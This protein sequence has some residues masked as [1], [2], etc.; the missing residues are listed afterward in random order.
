MNFAIYSRKSKYTSSG[1]S[2]ENQIN[3]CYE[4]I[5][6]N[7]AI[8]ENSIFIYKDEGFSGKNTNRP[9]FLQMMRELKT[10]NINCIVCYRLDRISRNVNDFS[11]LIEML[12]KNSISFISIRERF[13]TTTPMGKAMMYISSVFAQMER[14]TIAERI[15]DN[16]YKLAQ[17]GR[18]LGG[19]TPIGYK[20]EKISITSNDKTRHEF[21]L[22]LVEEE[23]VIVRKIYSIFLE[24]KRLSAVENYLYLNKIKTRSNKNYTS[25][26]IKDI[27]TNPVYCQ[28]DIKSLKYF[29]S[30]GCNIYTNE[31][32]IN[33]NVGY[34][35]YCKTKNISPSSS[36]RINT[37]YKEWI[38]S[39]GKHP[40]IIS[41]EN[42]IKTQNILKSIKIKHTKK[43]LNNYALL[44]GILFCK[45]TSPMRAK[46]YGDNK[47]IYMCENKEKSKNNNCNIKGIKG[48]TLDSLILEFII[49]NQQYSKKIYNKIKKEKN[50]TPEELFENLFINADINKKRKIIKTLI[51]FIIYDGKSVKIQY[52]NPESLN[53]S[54]HTQPLHA[55]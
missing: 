49:N 20:A 40:Y 23:S 55:R 17:T 34:M 6:Q 15:K 25:D 32:D 21:K 29:S 16:M 19:T 2:I 46:K 27:L 54:L 43:T 30:I 47:F 33:K 42:W 39:T 9:Q 5:K 36:V 12:E 11:S 24:K 1:E 52:K 50:T 14:E 41:S 10:K 35:S 44:S 13:D 45:C 31:S 37:S 7:F 8:N 48:N 3:M 53:T 28:L 18:W 4:Y 51:D 38:I 26:K 22:S